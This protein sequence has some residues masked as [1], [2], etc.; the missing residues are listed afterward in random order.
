MENKPGMGQ[1]VPKGFFQKV[2]L[3]TRPPPGVRGGGGGSVQRPG[4]SGSPIDLDL[5]R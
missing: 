1:Q 5:C 3:R 4:L 2:G